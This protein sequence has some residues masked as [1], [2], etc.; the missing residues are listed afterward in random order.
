M[1]REIISRWN[2]L[3][4]NED[5]VYHLGDFTLLGRDRA[6]AYARQLNGHI[7]VLA[8]LWHH[9]HFW[10]NYDFGDG[11]HYGAYGGMFSA[12]GH[13]VTIEPPVIVMERYEL[14]ATEH[15]QVIVLCHYPFAVW[16]RKHYGAW[17]LHGHSHMR[18]EG[19]GK[20]LDVGV[21]SHDFYPISLDKV[22]SYMKQKGKDNGN[23]MERGN[24]PPP[25]TTPT[26]TGHERTR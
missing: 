24:Y 14:S 26:A 9:D 17:H 7:H 8:N 16:D 21:D 18:Y 15:P 22:V 20:V 5:T 19:E 2:C 10:L 12:S 6:I 23:N 1:D 4:H 11:Y 13:V 3:V 25:N